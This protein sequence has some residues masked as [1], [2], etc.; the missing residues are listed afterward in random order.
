MS[1]PSNV[2]EPEVGVAYPAIS[3]DSVVFPAPDPP[4]MAVNVPGRAVSEILSSRVFP[5]TAKLTPWTSRPPVR[6]AASPRGNRAPPVNFRSTLPI[7]TTSPSARMA[8]PILVPLTN[9]PFMLWTLRISV[10]IGVGASNA[11]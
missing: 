10:P 8:D 4:M 11:W 5:A 2:T 1:C 3:R 6:V 9:V 7:V